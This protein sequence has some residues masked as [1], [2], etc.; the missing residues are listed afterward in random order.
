VRLLL[1]LPLVATPLL[2]A[3]PA[4]AASCCGTGPSAVEKLGSGE[5]ASFTLSLQGLHTTGGWD[6]S[7]AWGGE[8]GG[9][10][11]RAELAAA[12]ALGSRVQLGLSAPAQ[13]AWRQVDTIAGEGGGAGDLAVSGRVDPMPS[14]LTQAWPSVGITLALSLPTGRAEADANEPL[15]ADA[16]GLGGYELRPGVALDGDVGPLTYA[17]SGSVGLRQE[18]QGYGRTLQRAP[19]FALFGF[20][21]RWFGR[22]LLGASASTA[23]EGATSIDG[24]A[25]AGAERRRTTASLLGAFE[26]D[27]AWSLAA[28]ARA[29][30]PLGGL[31]QN[32]PGGV[33]GRLSLRWAWLNEGG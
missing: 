18:T 11:A 4:R 19:G 17:L 28:E 2:V 1:L 6:A 7:G 21:G 33:G 16:T 15:A 26:L 27:A 22:W 9:S 31:G 14:G 20:A 30:L 10:E 5:A 13:Y 12:V 24:R 8:T 3:R 25:M 23:W 32:E 29:E